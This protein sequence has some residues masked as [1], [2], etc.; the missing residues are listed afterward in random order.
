MFLHLFGICSYCCN[1]FNCCM[2]QRLALFV[3]SELINNVVTT[4]HREKIVIQERN[5]YSKQMSV[6][7]GLSAEIHPIIPSESSVSH[8]CLHC[9]YFTEFLTQAIYVCLPTFQD[10]SNGS[11]LGLVQHIVSSNTSFTRVS[12]IF[13]CSALVHGRSLHS[14]LNQDWSW[15]SG[16]MLIVK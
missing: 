9:F 15:T 3:L 4:M 1:L 13:K 6:Q 11:A 10:I 7:N 2:L 12:V 8:H 5:F 16:L 14:S